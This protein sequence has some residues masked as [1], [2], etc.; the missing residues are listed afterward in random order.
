MADPTSLKVTLFAALAV[1]V[2]PLA[3]EYSLILAGAVVGA[4]AG[5]SMR[6]IPLSGWAAPLAHIMMGVMMAL[7]ITPAGAAVALWALP[8]NLA[9]P[10]EALLPIV[11]MGIGAFW[12]PA[13]RF[14]P[15]VLRKW[16][17][18]QEASK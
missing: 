1:T 13:L 14:G 8:D 12:H 10:I 4:Y 16:F 6:E 15:I 7:L 9:L 5:L 2:G 18:Q 11:A 3:A 17:G